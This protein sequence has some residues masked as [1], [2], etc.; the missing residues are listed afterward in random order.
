M[1]LR[2][3]LASPGRAA[4]A[5]GSACART[6]SDRRH[7][8]SRESRASRLARS[9][10][11]CPFRLSPSAVLMALGVVTKPAACAAST[12]SGADHAAAPARAGLAAASKRKHSQQPA[13]A[14]ALNCGSGR[15]GAAM[16]RTQAGGAAPRVSRRE[17][18]AWNCGPGAGVGSPRVRPARKQSSRPLLP[19]ER[20]AAAVAGVPALRPKLSVAARYRDLPVSGASPARGP[21]RAPRRWFSLR[22]RHGRWRR[23]GGCSTG[24]HARAGA[25]RA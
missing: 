10:R 19:R 1:A 14:S 18:E 24:A 20:T 13:V 15:L 21:T 3:S 22:P 23:G 4:H 7:A 8:T 17:G 16:S 2:V 9:I 11:P 5:R 25:A 12:S 6:A